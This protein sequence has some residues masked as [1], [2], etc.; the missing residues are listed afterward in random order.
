M[1]TV[2]NFVYASYLMGRT[3]Y[4][5]NPVQTVALGIVTVVF[6]GSIFGIIGV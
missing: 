6:F 2:R 1:K 5:L 3:S 4:E